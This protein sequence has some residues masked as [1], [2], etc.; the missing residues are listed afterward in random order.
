MELTLPL[1]KEIAKPLKLVILSISLALFIPVEMRPIKIEIALKHGEKPPVDLK[2]RS[3][4]M[5]DRVR[6]GLAYRLVRMAQ[7]LQLEWIPL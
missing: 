4:T 3:F 7:P 2:T 1:T 6:Q 5:Q